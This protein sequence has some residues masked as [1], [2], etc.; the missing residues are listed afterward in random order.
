MKIKSMV[1]LAIII[2]VIAAFGTAIMAEQKEKKERFEE[3]GISEKPAVFMRPADHSSGQKEVEVCYASK[4]PT[5]VKIK[6][7]SM[8]NLDKASKWDRRTKPE[9]ISTQNL[10]GWSCISFKSEISSNFTMETSVKLLNN[11]WGDTQRNYIMKRDGII[12]VE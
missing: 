11:Y 7:E 6:L 10:R 8:V 9:N 3:N 4:T 1:M 2:I 12:T 5:L